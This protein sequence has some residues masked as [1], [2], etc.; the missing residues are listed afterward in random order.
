MHCTVWCR[1]TQRALTL[2]LGSTWTACVTFSP[3]TCSSF[4]FSLF[5]VSFWARFL[6]HK[7]LTTAFVLSTASTL[8]F[9]QWLF[10][11]ILTSVSAVSSAAA[12]AFETG[13]DF[14]VLPLQASICSPAH[15]ALQPGSLS[16]SFPSVPRPHAPHDSR[17][18]NLSSVFK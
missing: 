9:F 10:Q 2:Q 17:K 7:I 18:A 8:P 12:L 3:K 1:F 14:P 5:A 11:S 16:H 6:I 4:W 13:M 15:P